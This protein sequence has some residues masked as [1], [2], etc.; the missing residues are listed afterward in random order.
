MID[1]IE[2]ARQALLLGAESALAI[3]A[4]RVLSTRER[5]PDHADRWQRLCDEAAALDAPSEP[6]S[7]EFER[8]TLDE[9]RLSRWLVWFCAAIELF[10]EAAAAASILAEDE[11]VHLLTPAVFAR[12]MHQLC[13][14]EFT[15]GLG[16]A[17]EGAP[18]RMERVQRVEVV[19]GKP[20]TQAACRL[21]PGELSSILGARSAGTSRSNMVVVHCSPASNT[22]Y[23]PAFVA[24]AR[25]LLAGRGVLGLHGSSGRALR[26]FALDLCALEKE[27]ALLISAETALPS[28]IDVAALEPGLPILQLGRA[29]AEPEALSSF[30]EAISQLGRA[31]KTPLRI[32]LLVPQEVDELPAGSLAVPALNAMVS[33]RIWKLAGLGEADATSLGRRFAVDLVEARAACRDAEAAHA[34][35][36]G[37]V[38]WARA[39]S[40]M[41]RVR[42]A[43]RMGKQVATLRSN[44][45]LD[46][47]VAPRDLTSQLEDIVGWYAA[48]PR[49]FGEM[50][51]ASESGLGRGLVC[52]FAGPSGTGKT[53]AAQCLS[54]AL[55][56]NLYRI[57]LSQVVSKYIGETEKALARIFDE[58]AAGH[59]MLFFDEADSLFGKRS[60]VRDA[61]DRYANIEVGY[62]LQKLEEFEGVAILA[63]NLRNNMD[64]AFMRRIGF[65]LDFPMPDRDMRQRLWEQSLPAKQFRQPTLEFGDLVE[66][67]RLSGGN[68]RNIGVAAAHLAAATPSGQITTRHL[69][70]ATFRELQ[71]CGL[72]RTPADFGQL[73]PLLEE[74]R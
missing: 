59:G 7:F 50:N 30:V 72:S 60:A 67:L 27:S 55:D 66:R 26:Q 52:L 9:E 4:D 24:R 54:N 58:A 45:T 35:A 46:Q 56:L 14:V 74:R 71:K 12:L 32:V 25:R 3:P 40:K 37:S 41:V 65:V 13:D 57:D 73:A 42:G 51:M 44:A 6:N 15:R 39:V 49:V 70:K 48:S 29:T 28:P 2:L 62:L 63:T 1:G 20:L 19:S 10:P 21:A 69:V 5:W 61:H 34:T 53:L 43:R 17:L 64:P 23:D 16:E 38:S 47:L 68:I 22:A 18:L 31:R 11:R 36:G 33:E 8:R